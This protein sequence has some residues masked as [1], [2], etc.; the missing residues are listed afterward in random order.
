MA[1]IDRVIMK[2]RH[3]VVPEV[4]QKQE[5][6]QIHINHLAIEK[7]KLLVHR[8]IYWI[9]MPADIENH[10]KIVLHALNFSKLT[11]K[12]ILFIKKFQTVGGGR[13][14]YVYLK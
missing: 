2:G 12:K 8:S 4:L 1:I 5:H 13:S 10:I 11:Q 6:H 3:I 7:T 14:K 9:G